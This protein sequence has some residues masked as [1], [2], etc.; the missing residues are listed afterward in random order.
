MGNEERQVPDSGSEASGS[1]PESQEDTDSTTVSRTR[2]IGTTALPAW[3]FSAR[4]AFLDRTLLYG[5]LI[6]APFNTSVAVLKHAGDRGLELAMKQNTQSAETP[7]S[8]MV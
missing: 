1:D 7:P 3:R 8:D 6:S 5:G 4:S 2:F